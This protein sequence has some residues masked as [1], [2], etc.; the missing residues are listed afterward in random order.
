MFD[1]VLDTPL[2]RLHL[3]IF[4]VII[5]NSDGIFRIPKWLEDNHP[6]LEYLQ[7]ISLTTCLWIARRGRYSS[8]SSLLILCN[9]HAPWRKTSTIRINGN[10]HH[11]F[12]RIP[13]LRHVLVHSVDKTHVLILTVELI[14]LLFLNIFSFNFCWA[15]VCVCFLWNL[16]NVGISF[17]M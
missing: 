9:T 12:I 5:A 16:F 10:Y 7:N 3:V 11:F 4:C 13:I 6:S 17:T 1:N 15:H 2:F 14:R 8:P